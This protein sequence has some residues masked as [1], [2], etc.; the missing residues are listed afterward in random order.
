MA[1]MNDNKTTPLQ[2]NEP[3]GLMNPTLQDIE[4]V[5]ALLEATPDTPL[6]MIRVCENNITRVP[7]M[8][9]VEKQCPCRTI[10]IPGDNGVWRASSL[11]LLQGDTTKL[12]VALAAYLLG[13]GEVGLWLEREAA[14]PDAWVKREGNP[15]REW[16]ED[17][18]GEVYQ[19]T[20]SVRLGALLFSFSCLFLWRLVKCDRV[21]SDNTVPC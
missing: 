20:V 13:Y 17:Y 19:D 14:K 9:A 8:E 2:L 10:I 6:Y 3:E 4:A 12:L 16:M 1:G 7:F 21:R 18:A 15:Y 11:M 5:N